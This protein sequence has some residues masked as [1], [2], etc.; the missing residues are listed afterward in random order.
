MP[1][2]TSCTADERKLAQLLSMRTTELAAVRLGRIYH[3]RPFAITKRD[4]RERR[5][6]APSPAL[7]ALQRNLLH[8]YLETLPVHPAATGF[9]SGL[10]IVNNAQRHAGQALFATLDLQDFFEATSAARVRAFFLRQGWRDPA[11]KTLMRI[12]VYRDGLPQGAPTSPCL[13][14]LVNYDLDKALAQLAKAANATYTRYGD[15]LTFSWPTEYLP[16]HF[17]TAVRREIARAGYTIQPRKDWQVFY[18]TQEPH[19]TGLVIGQDGYVHAPA[20]A[21]HKTF[22]LRLR[23]WLT[24]DPHLRAIVSGYRG[25]LNM[26]GLK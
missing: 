12:C 24:G 10:S 1:P 4:G 9:I 7:K 2:A 13:S 23:A 21:H 17:E 19:I 22:W 6:L 25:F 14:N 20:A 26:P 16:A 15:D 5:I 11:L 8:N 3:Y 18:A